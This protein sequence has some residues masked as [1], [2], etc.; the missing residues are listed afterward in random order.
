MIRPTLLL[1][2]DSNELRY[3]RNFLNPCEMST[4][5]KNNKSNGKGGYDDEAIY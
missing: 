3:Y 4:I 1:L 2:H 5:E